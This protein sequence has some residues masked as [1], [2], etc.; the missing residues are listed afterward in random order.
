MSQTGAHL[1]LSSLQTIGH[2]MG[3]SS[4]P[5]S[6]APTATPTALQTNVLTNSVPVGVANSGQATCCLL[7]DNQRCH[8]IAGNASYSKRIEKQVTQRK[9]RL[10]VDLRS[11]HTYICEH[12]K[13]MIQSIRSSNKRK[14]KDSEDDDITADNEGHTSGQT[15]GQDVDLL[16]LQ[17][18]TLRRYKKHYRIQTRP[19]LNKSQLAEVLPIVC[20]F[21][22]R[23]QMSDRQTLQRHFKSMPIYEKEAITYFIYM[24]KCNKNKLDHNPAQGGAKSPALALASD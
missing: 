3:I 8:R 21:T 14:R 18:N 5:P 23:C 15:S 16:A 24:V 2:N 17:V 22:Q 13:Q 9:L 20:S 19:G 12:H 10:T 4:Q 1:P 7:E 6:A 11:H